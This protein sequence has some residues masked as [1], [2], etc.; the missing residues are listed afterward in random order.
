[1]RTIRKQVLVS[2][3]IRRIYMQA[4]KKTSLR[5][6]C[7]FLDQEARCMIY[8]IRPLVCRINAGLAVK[9]DSKISD[10]DG[11]YIYLDNDYITNVQLMEFWL[12]FK[13]V[14][15]KKVVELIRNDGLASR[16]NLHNL[17]F[18]NSLP[19]NLNRRL[20][21]PNTCILDRISKKREIN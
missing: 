13:I 17:D 10:I 8:S 15:A 1:K 16:R 7:P 14:G 3:H 11:Y 9:Q 19:K 4:G 12:M 21:R 18:K 2:Y 6:R 5:L 20:R